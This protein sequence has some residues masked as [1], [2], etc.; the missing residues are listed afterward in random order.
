MR[1]TT[2][3]PAIKL[4][5]AIVLALSVGA[6]ANRFS[7]Q[8]IA[9]SLSARELRLKESSKAAII[10]TGI[11][12][13]YFDEHF[14]LERVVDLPADRRVVWKYSI[15]EYET[16][17]NDA[18]GFFTDEKGKRFNLHSIR[19]TLAGAHDIK[20]TISRKRAEE[21][22]SKCLGNYAP[23]PVLFQAFG[24]P[25]R[26][27]LLLTA[28]SIPIYPTKKSTVEKPDVKQPSNATTTAVESQRNVPDSE[29]KKG[30]SSEKP[31][32][33]TAFVDLESGECTKGRAQAGRP[34]SPE[35]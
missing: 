3:F 11:S 16:I 20:T 1:V 30:S 23:G 14:K 34:P 12:P 18:V 6:Q 35:K 26:A 13:K 2:A 27:S 33:Y 15:G 4:A 32:I 24:S 5:F 28:S 9:D 19:N 29:L 7:G 22:M 31:I 21:L 8:S 17:L 10:D 25:P